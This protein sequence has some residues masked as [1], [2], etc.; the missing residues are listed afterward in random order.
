MPHTVDGVQQ[1][2]RVAKNELSNTSKSQM[3]HLLV[4]ESYKPINAAA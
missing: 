1:S 4:H 3:S 2:V